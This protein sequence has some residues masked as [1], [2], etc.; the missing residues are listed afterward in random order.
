MDLFSRH[1]VGWALSTRMTKDEALAMA[2]RRRRPAPGLLHHS[3]QG[4][5]YTCNEYQAL[6]A[7]HGIVASASRK[8]DC[9]DKAVIV[10]PP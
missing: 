4:S 9:W 8:G 5:Q 6:L 2:L 1:I 10:N 3:H 7:A